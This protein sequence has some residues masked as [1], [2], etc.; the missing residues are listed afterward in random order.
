VQIPWEQLVH[1][2][3][4]LGVVPGT[5]VV[6]F[7]VMH[8]WVFWLYKGRLADRQAEIN[9]IAAENKEYRDRFTALLD[10]QLKIPKNLLPPGTPPPGRRKKRG[11][12]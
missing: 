10:K 8:G 4:E 1:F 11:G 3:K 12:K 7:W 9:R 2:I 5:L 6:F